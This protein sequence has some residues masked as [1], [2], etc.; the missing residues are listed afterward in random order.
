M[1]PKLASNLSF[2]CLNL[3]IDYR[4]APSHSAD[5]FFNFRRIFEDKT[6]KQVCEDQQDDSTG[7][8]IIRQAL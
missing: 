6:Q 7:K 8:G 2:S 3:K 4:H 5:V 1:L